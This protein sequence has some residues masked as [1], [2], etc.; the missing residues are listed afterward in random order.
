MRSNIPRPL[1]ITSP[2]SSVSLLPTQSH[3]SY[4]H[5]CTHTHTHQHTHTLTHTDTTHTLTTPHRL[6]GTLVHPRLILDTLRPADAIHTP[7]YTHTTHTLHTHYTHTRHTHY[8][9]TSTRT[10]TCTYTHTYTHTHTR[11]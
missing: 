8:T 10:R 7:C 6:S 9:R 2:H 5:P 11:T 4:T 1:D 3:L